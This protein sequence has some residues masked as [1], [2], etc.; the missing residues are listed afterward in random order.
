MKKRFLSRIGTVQVHLCF[1]HS[2]LC[3]S[4]IGGLCR[5][6]FRAVHQEA[7]CEPVCVCV[8]GCAASSRLQ[9]AEGNQPFP[10]TAGGLEGVGF[11]APCLKFVMSVASI[12]F[13]LQ[14]HR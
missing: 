11:K 2:F 7:A 5:R 6:P 9:H 12:Q 1:K 3:S 4:V 10:Q 8:T 13:H 14:N